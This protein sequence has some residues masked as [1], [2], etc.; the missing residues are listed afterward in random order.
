MSLSAPQREQLENATA[1]YQAQVLEAKDYLLARGITG[2]IAGS[3][4][5]GVVV[6]P[7]LGHEQM[8]GRLAI[9]S[10]VSEALEAYRIRGVEGYTDPDG[11]PDDVGSEFADVLIRL[12][13][14][15]AAYGID[16]EAEYE[17]KMAYNEKRPWRHGG[18]RL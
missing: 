8:A 3:A 2:P 16:L 10:E 7:L 18:K 4:R 5:L 14:A 11:K 1:Y 12:L 6:N 9:H 17:R 13:D 15:S